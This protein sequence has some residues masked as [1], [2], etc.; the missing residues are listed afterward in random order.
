[1]RRPRP[2]GRIG[3]G[4]AVGRTAL[5]DLG[6]TAAALLVRP[7]NAKRRTSPARTSESWDR[8]WL[9][10]V[11]CWTMAAFCW[12]TWSI[13][14]TAVLT[15]CRPVACSRAEAA[16]EVTRPLIC[17]TRAKRPSSDWPV[18]PTNATPVRTWLEEARS[19]P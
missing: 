11:D 13:W 12:V 4:E 10:A 19:A 16:M 6:G 2:A 15:C 18:W 9:A 7:L 17:S 5:G 1:V 8:L 3:A 14:F